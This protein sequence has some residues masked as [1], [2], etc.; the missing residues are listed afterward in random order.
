M[1]NIYYEPT[2]NTTDVESV[3]Y[4][5]Q[6]AWKKFPDGT[7]VAA[8]TGRVHIPWAHDYN[9]VR[10]YQESATVESKYSRIIVNL[11]PGDVVYIPGDKEGALVR[12]SSEVKAGPIEGGS[13]VRTVKNCAHQYIDGKCAECRNS[14]LEVTPHQIHPYL[15]EGHIVEPF[16]ALYREV[17][18]VGW[19]KY[20]NTVKKGPLA[21]IDSAGLRRQGWS[22]LT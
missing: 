15:A 1:Q 21:R 19:V 5:R 10:L 17:E 8:Y 7:K 9:A 11:S 12:I 22:R 18:F 3:A 16:W 13:V 6:F 14:I 2:N 4:I 20:T